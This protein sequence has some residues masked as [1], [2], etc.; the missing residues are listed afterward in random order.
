MLRRIPL[1]RPLA[2]L[3]VVAWM[4][5]AISSQVHHLVVQHVICPEHGELQGIHFD[6]A[7]HAAVD[8]IGAPEAGEKHGDHGCLFL[9][10]FSSSTPPAIVEA[11]VRAWTPPVSAPLPE[12][13]GARAPPLRFAPKT[14]PPLA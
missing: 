1:L 12:S 13:L 5:A 9:A 3:L 10:G 2:A 14:S 8:Q 6:G 11:P 4:G 7:E